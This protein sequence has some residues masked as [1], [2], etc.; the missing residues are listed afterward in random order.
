MFSY[1]DKKIRDQL[2]RSE[3]L[4]Y[5]N[6]QGERVREDYQGTPVI[7]VIGP[8][9]MPVTIAGKET[10][11]EW[12]PFVRRVE[13]RQ[14]LDIAN[15]VQQ[16]GKEAFR[17]LI[18]ERMSV[19]SILRTPDFAQLDEP[20]VRI[21]SCCMTGDV[22]GS[23]RCECGPQLA[24]A[25]ESIAR[26][27]GAVVYMSS[28]EGRGIG[29]WA[30]AVTYLLQDDGQDTYQANVSLGLPEDSRDFSDAAVILKYM[31]KGKSIRLMSNNPLKFEQ[32]IAAGQPVKEPVRH[33]V[34]IGK[35]NERYMTSKKE[36]GHKI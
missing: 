16:G 33:V 20:L 26:E 25:F 18:Q 31:L 13:L 9:P 10:M 36:K 27:S 2:E 32:L 11:L 7:S 23:M 30:K 29:L 3:K 8:I 6:Q 1:V 12:F 19:N 14:V 24:L 34:G 21:H 15:E 28:H 5:L 17:Q 4:F 22:F 35:Y